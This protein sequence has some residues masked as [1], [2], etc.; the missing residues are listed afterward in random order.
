MIRTGSGRA[1]GI[2]AL[3]HPAPSVF[4]W[5][6]ERD[7]GNDGYSQ[8]HLREI[9]RRALADMLEIGVEPGFRGLAAGVAQA[10]EQAPFRVK[11]RGRAELR[12]QGI[13]ADPVHEHAPVPFA[14]ELARIDQLC[15]K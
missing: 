13:V 11:L 4:P 5:R 9:D 2:S 10:A 15:R 3:A 7:P 6:A 8:K 1:G 14:V 12:H